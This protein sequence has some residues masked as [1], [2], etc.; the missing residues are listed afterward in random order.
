[1]QILTRQVWESPH[2]DKLHNVINSHFKNEVQ[3]RVSEKDDKEG[4]KRTKPGKVRECSG[5][6]KKRCH[7]NSFRSKIWSQR[8]CPSEQGVV[9]GVRGTKTETMWLGPCDKRG[10]IWNSE[11]P[12]SPSVKGIP[13]LRDVDAHSISS[14]PL[15][16]KL[17]NHV[18]LWTTC[19]RLIPPIFVMLTLIC[20]TLTFIS[21]DHNPALSCWSCPICW[22]LNS[23]LDLF[24]VTPHPPLQSASQPMI[25][26]MCLTCAKLCAR[27]RGYPM[28]RHWLTSKSL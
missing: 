3:L 20:V 19:R 8:K 5:V 26:I 25:H 22:T 2:K 14:G 16:V 11:L 27:W 4:E 17:R 28:Q 18:P 7:L 21:S 15:F 12:S 9:A 10:W 1:M 6:G 13:T 24:P 23:S